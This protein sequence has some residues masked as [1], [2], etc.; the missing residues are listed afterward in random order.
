MFWVYILKCNDDFLY[1]GITWNLE[2]RLTEH[3]RG[4]TPFTKNRL[5]VLLLYKKEYATRGEA[6]KREKEIKGWSR[7]KKLAFIQKQLK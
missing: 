7:E 4:H 6:A 5:P 1:T 3:K 2:R